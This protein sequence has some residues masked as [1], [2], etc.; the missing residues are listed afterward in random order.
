M[1]KE[2]IPFNPVVPLDLTIPVSEPPTTQ[3]P[4]L[5]RGKSRPRKRA[6]PVVTRRVLDVSRSAGRFTTRVRRH[7]KASW[8]RIKGGISSRLARLDPGQLKRVLLACGVA[9]TAAL[10]IISL[11][12]HTALIVVLLAVLGALVVLKLWNRLLTLGF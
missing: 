5:L 9:S 10:V 8:Q 11:A 7:A 4:T 6:H 3:V 2:E 1:K 12:K